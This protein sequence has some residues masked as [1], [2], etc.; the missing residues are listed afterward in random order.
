MGLK[1]RPSS[2]KLR[3]GAHGPCYKNLAKPL[4]IQTHLRIN[5]VTLCTY[6][7]AHAPSAATR[8]CTHMRRTHTHVHDIVPRP[9]A[10]TPSHAGSAQCPRASKAQHVAAREAPAQLEREGKGRRSIRLCLFPPLPSSSRAFPCGPSPRPA[11]ASSRRIPRWRLF[12][13]SP[14]SR[15]GLRHQ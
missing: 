12:S 4:Q 2:A 11:P 14:S 13:S 8:R 3:G 1:Y 7:L 9:F 10:D 5:H 6:A 15:A